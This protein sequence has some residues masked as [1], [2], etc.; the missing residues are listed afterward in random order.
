MTPGSEANYQYNL[1]TARVVN[2]GE[3]IAHTQAL[4]LLCG[5]SCLN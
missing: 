3:I 5:C 1:I 4:V 2:C